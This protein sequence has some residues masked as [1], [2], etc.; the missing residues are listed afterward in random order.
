M[1]AHS[2]RSSFSDARF[3]VIVVGG[4]IYGIMTA[5]EASARKLRV[6]L[7]EA[8]DWGS[9]TSYSWLRILHGGLRY[10]QKMDLP[11]FYES[12]RERK[13]FLEHFPHLVRPVRCVMPLYQ[14]GSHPRWLMQ[15]ALTLNDLLSIHRNRGLPRDQHLERGRILSPAEVLEALPYAAREDLKGG[16]CWVDAVAREPQL[17]LLELLQWCRARG[18]VCLNYTRATEVLKTD[19]KVT[20]L[21]VHNVLDGTDQKYLAPVVINATG[22]WAPGIARRAGHQRGAAPAASWAWNVLFDVPITGESAGAV[23]AREQGAQTFFVMPWQGRALIGTGHAPVEGRDESVAVPEY[24]IER[25]V[26]QVARAAPSLDLTMSKVSRV[27]GGRLPISSPDPLRLTAR[28]WIVDHRQSGAAGLYSVWGIKY[29]TALAVARRVVARACG[30]RAAPRERYRPEGV[31]PIRI[32]STESDR[33]GSILPEL[34]GDNLKRVADLGLATE[35]CHLDDLVLRRCGLGDHP[36]S[37]RELA[38]PMAATM[39]W[40]NERRDS[41][42]SRFFESTADVPGIVRDSRVDDR[43]IKDQ[44]GIQT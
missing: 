11:R 20:G 36:G 9:G 34:Q 15:A 37:A 38:G 39:P 10:L 13:W 1:S 14:T 35:A 31:E 28:P 19:G 23:T 30:N 29:T 22:H 40:N 2:S 4:G 43:N 44:D 5:L 3:D 7:V 8:G 26:E 41:E 32:P 12:V 18:T 25:F 42:L 16:A 17:L 6:L 24:L 21:R 27:F 33:H